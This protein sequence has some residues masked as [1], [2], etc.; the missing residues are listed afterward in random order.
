MPNA[1]AFGS[2]REVVRVCACSTTS[3]R[4]KVRRCVS[5][6][7]IVGRGFYIKLTYAKLTHVKLKLIITI[8]AQNIT[9]CAAVQV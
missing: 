8:T 3:V 4:A 2:K 5:K 1:P 9:K 6:C 7:F